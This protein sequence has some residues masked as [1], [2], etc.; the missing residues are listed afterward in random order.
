MKERIKFY[1]HSISAEFLRLIALAAVCACLL[2][3]G[4]GTVSSFVIQS[5]FE[6]EEYV[7]KKNAEQIEELVRY[8]E[9]HNVSVTEKEQLTKWMKKHPILSM[10]VFKDGTLQYD[11]AYPDLE[12]TWSVDQDD[13]YG[14]QTYYKVEFADGNADVFISGYYGY[15]F[16]IVS[17][18]VR[19]LLA[20]FLFLVIIVLGIRRTIRYIRRLSSEIA[21]LE[22]G[23]LDYEITV[24]GQNELADLARGLNTMRVSLKERMENEARLMQNHANLITE[25]SHDLRTPLTSVLVYTE[26]LKKHA[27]RD[28]E[29]LQQYIEKIE[30][31]GIQMKKRTDNLF[32]YALSGSEHGRKTCT[33]TFTDAFYE[34]ISDMCAYLEEKNFEMNVAL[35][36][37]PKQAMVEIDAEYLDRVFDNIVSN[38]VKYGDNTAP[39][40]IS[41][42]VSDNVVRL[43]FENQILKNSPYADSSNIGL[44]NIENMMHS[45]GGSSEAGE[46]GNT[47]HVVLKFPIGK[48]DLALSPS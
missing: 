9:K 19:I 37:V 1:R 29:Q 33:E 5:H 25:M 39:I 18:I 7:Q 3:A 28:E 12:D 14:W 8:I 32:E 23:D 6:N 38:I 42:E 22:S 21:I 16:S 41:S 40:E 15:Q 4:L 34:R 10:Q 24:S 13:Y 45:M 47:F 2:F 36:K 43:V 11:S 44:K 30:A 20:V 27:Y 17:M 31:K 46:D 48:D 35:D 26:I